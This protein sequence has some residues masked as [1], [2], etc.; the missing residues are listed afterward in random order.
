MRGQTPRRGDARQHRRPSTTRFRE[1]SP[2]YIE[3]AP[4]LS[5]QG[6]DD[7]GAE[8][9]RKLR[10]L[11]SA[12]ATFPDLL[13]TLLW[14]L[15]LLTAFVYPPAEIERGKEPSSYLPMAPLTH[16]EIA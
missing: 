12:E 3:H 4:A 13:G 8:E 7:H 11:E 10:Y 16:A 9:P 6:L 15:H 5:R 14:Y 2:R 1:N